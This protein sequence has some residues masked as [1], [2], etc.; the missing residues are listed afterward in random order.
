MDTGNH[1]RAL[2]LANYEA[3][4]GVPNAVWTPDEGASDLSSQFDILEYTGTIHST[5]CTVGASHTV[6][7]HTEQEYPEYQGVRFEYILHASPQYRKQV[8]DLLL[9]IAAYP[10]LQHFTYYP[11]CAIPI[12]SPVIDGSPMTALYFTYPYRDDPKIYTETPWGQVKCGS[13]LVHTWWVF[14]V[15]LAEVQY[16]QK[17]DADAFEDLCYERWSR[18]YDGFDFFRPSLVEP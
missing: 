5:Y 4:K 2:V 10:F 13:I 12:G 18:K 6:I 7:P 15:Y 17:H 11:G 14:P 16:I 8:C 9:M 3:W 1:A